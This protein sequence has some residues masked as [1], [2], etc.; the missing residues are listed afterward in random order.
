MVLTSEGR[1]KLIDEL[2]YRE[3]EKNAEILEA[4]REARAQGDLSENA[5]YDAAKEEQAKNAA[6]ISDIRKILATARVVEVSA[7]EASVGELSV[8]LGST[9]ELENEKGT[10]AKYTIVGST[11][12]DS[13][14][15][16]ISSDSPVGAA[17]IG[18]VVGDV[19]SYLTPSGKERKLKITDIERSAS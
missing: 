3:G 17:V 7:G 18:H 1:Q 13:L 8:S 4:I 5:E 9:V 16:R 10:A 11:E 15:N 12:T 19:V 6:R 14:S 2:E